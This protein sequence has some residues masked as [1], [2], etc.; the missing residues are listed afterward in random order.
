MP[1]TEMADS[2]AQ[3]FPPA[4]ISVDQYHRMIASGVFDEDDGVELLE[5]CV[6]QKTGKN[7]PH[8]TA[9]RLADALLSRSV[10]AGWHVR[11]QAAVT[12]PDSEPEP[13]LAVVRGDVRDYSKNHPSPGD[14]AVVVEV[15]DT[16][17]LADRRKGL[18]YAREG[19]PVYWIINLQDAVIELHS[20]PQLHGAEA[21]YSVIRVYG[22]GDRIPLTIAG[23]VAVE[24]PVDDLL[25]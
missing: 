1:T 21:R 14:V 20:Q 5:G 19:I 23:Q 18:I 6:V 24:L 2:L 4:R 13:D 22:R 16:S 25:P 7:P 3:Y 9:T 12:F 17:L 11:N 10:P 8:E 15:A